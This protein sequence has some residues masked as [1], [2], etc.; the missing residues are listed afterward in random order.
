MVGHLCPLC[1]NAAGVRAES[2]PTCTGGRACYTR[3]H[4]VRHIS[5]AE[6]GMADVATNVLHQ[7]ACAITIWTCSAG[8][9]RWGAALLAALS[10]W[11]SGSRI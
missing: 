5:N 6:H 2:G 10:H 1:T 9:W 4:Q 11:R 8:Q 7:G 3:G